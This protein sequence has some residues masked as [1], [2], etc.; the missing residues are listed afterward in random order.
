LHDLPHR[1]QKQPPGYSSRSLS[2][3]LSAGCSGHAYQNCSAFVAK[4]RPNPSVEA[5]P[6]GGPPG[7]PSSLCLSSARRAWRPTAGPRLTSNVR[8]HSEPPYNHPQLRN[9]VGASERS[10]AR[11]ELLPRCSWLHASSRRAHG[12]WNELDPTCTARAERD[13][14]AS[15]VVR[16]D[17]AWCAAKGHGEH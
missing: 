12:A 4:V 13:D 8:P 16:A 6:N 5:R 14:R 3:C 2:R 17:E 9:T 1:Y 7:P 10:T 15:D 11:E